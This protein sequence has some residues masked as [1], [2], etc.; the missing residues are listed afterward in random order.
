[1]MRKNWGGIIAALF[2]LLLVFSN[3]LLTTFGIE[4]LKEFHENRNL[5][6]KPVFKSGQF[7][8]TKFISDFDAY[9]SDHFS[10]RKPLLISLNTVKYFLFNVSPDPTAMPSKKGWIFYGNTLLRDYSR[11]DKPAQWYVEKIEQSLRE[12]QA[13]LNARGTGFIFVL[14]PNKHNI[15]PQYMPSYLV[16]GEGISN[17]E[18]LVERLTK[19][20]PGA[21]ANV[22]PALRE[23][24]KHRR[25]YYKIDTHW[26]HSGAREAAEV[27]FHLIKKSFPGLKLKPLPEMKDKLEVLSPG[28]F[29]QVMGVP[30]REEEA[31]PVPRGGWNWKNFPGAKLKKLLPEHARVFQRINPGAPPTRVLVLGDSFMGRFD[32]YIAEMFGNSIFVNLWDTP[33]TADNRFPT[34]FIETIDPDIVILLFVERRLQY[35]HKIENVYYY[36]AENPAGVCKAINEK[37]Q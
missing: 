31:T 19:A 7:S 6:P 30:L 24:A 9:I 32:K 27:V 22:F 29:G 14:T 10:F 37:Q 5:A 4:I 8:L 26:N 1:M 17:G 36:N 34:G 35:D 16:K 11:S 33:L 18:Q 20:L 21:V 12:K 28:S 3:A 23:T 15:Y 25:V 13:W 2:F